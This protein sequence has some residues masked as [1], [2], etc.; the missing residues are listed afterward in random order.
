MRLAV[1]VWFAN[2]NGLR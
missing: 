1:M 2:G